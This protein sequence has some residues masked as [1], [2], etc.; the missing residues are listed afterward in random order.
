ML[1]E[2]VMPQFKVL[3]QHSLDELRKIIKILSQKDYCRYSNRA[4]SGL[5]TVHRSNGGEISQNVSS[6]R[7][8]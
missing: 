8:S 3:S 6:I 5:E 4:Y 1:T 7:I 2:T